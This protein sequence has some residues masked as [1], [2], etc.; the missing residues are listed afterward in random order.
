MSVNLSLLFLILIC[1]C[2]FCLMFDGAKTAQEAP[3]RATITESC[4]KS[5]EE[6]RSG[7]GFAAGAEFH[8]VCEHTWSKTKTCDSNSKPKFS[9]NFHSADVGSQRVTS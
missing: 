4:T 2:G 6:A 5:C 9:C 8:P 3:I 1:V 7:V